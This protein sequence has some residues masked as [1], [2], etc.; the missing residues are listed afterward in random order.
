MKIEKIQ[1]NQLKPY[2]NNAKIH[3][4]E[5]IEQIILS[6][7]EFGF[8]DPVAIDENNMIIEGHGRVLA[9]QEMGATEVEAIR[10]T[11]MTEE[12]KHAYIH[13]HNQLT[14]NTGFDIEILE[15]ELKNITSIDMGQFG[16]DLDF[17][18]ELHPEDF[19]DDEPAGSIEAKEPRV[20]R[21]Q[22]WQCGKHRI[23]CGDSTDPKDVDALCDGLT[24]DLCV[25]DPPYNVA[26][27]GGTEEHLT[28]MN[29]DMDDHRFYLFLRDF[30]IQMLR[31][32]KPGGGFYIFHADSEGLNFRAA[33]REA[34]CDIRQNLIWVKNA[35]NLSRQD[36]QWKH[37]PILYGWKD[38]GA[39]YFIDD[40]C[41][42]TVFEDRPD[43]ESMDRPQLLQ[44]AKRLLAALD[45]AN[46]TILHENKPHRSELHP[47]MKPVPLVQRLIQNSSRRGDRVL[48]L[49]GGSGTTMMACD[50]CGRQAFIMELDPKYCDAAIERWETESGMEAVL[51]N[52]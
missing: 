46:T 45:Q 22:I 31:V 50:N 47:T 1:I 37:E 52:G 38:G 26:Y 11:G 18:I 27:E 42:T 8:N 10:L 20:K 5:Q 9:L 19:D 15:Q 23:M 28:I 6:I 12:Q 17:D 44:T 33:L 24:M 13:V 4:P 32:L 25:T 2:E 16:F 43:L 49:F 36:Y 40:R 39:H 3:T 21:G 35:L 41:Q 34:G 51:I 48:D 7:R 30:Y 14:M 29:D